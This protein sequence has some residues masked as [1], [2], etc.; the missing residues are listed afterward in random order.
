MS[1]LQNSINYYPNNNLFCRLL[2]INSEKRNVKLSLIGKFK[3]FSKNE[4]T[5]TYSKHN[6]H[7]I[8]LDIP[9]Y[10]FISSN[11]YKPKI[12]EQNVI[13]W[14]EKLIDAINIQ[15][16]YNDTLHECW[17][18]KNYFKSVKIIKKEI[19]KNIEHYDKLFIHED[20]IIN[21][22]IHLSP[23]SKSISIFIDDECHCNDRENEIEY[24]FYQKNGRNHF[25]KHNK[26]I[27]YNETKKCFI[28]FYS[29][30][31]LNKHKKLVKMFE[32]II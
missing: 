5:Y 32:E 15:V 4:F 27:K 6:N 16:I 14:F 30:T 8:V 26:N 24:I 17:L 13:I 10:D 31:S 12:Y 23:F 9:W 20:R 22:K 18:K 1:R 3:Y 25:K 21:N 28:T 19:P 7:N 2:L 29:R 11:T